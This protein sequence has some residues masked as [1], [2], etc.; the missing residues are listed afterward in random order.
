MSNNKT[1]ISLF[2]I[3]I[4]NVF[5]HSQQDSQYTQYIY[6]TS[7]INPAYAG[8]RETIS[9]FL[10]HRNQWLGLDGGPVTNN[11]AI[12]LPLGYSNFG[13]GLSFTNDKIGP[14]SENEIT[15]DLAYFIQIAKNYKLSVGIKAT[16]NLFH[17][18]I[19]KLTIYDTSD[20]QFQA[21]STEFSPNIGAGLF[22]FS[23]KNYIG[24]SI[25]NFFETY[26]YNDNTVS[27]AKEKI[28]F[29]LIAGK[30]FEIHQNL[31]F[32][33]AIL[34]KVVEGAPIQTDITTNFLFFDKLT[35]GAAYRW[36]VALSGLA[37][38]QISE[39]W[40]VGYGYD[41]E[42]T[43]LN[44]YNSGSHELFLRYELINK[45]KITAPRFF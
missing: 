9:A 36:D 31:K 24:I 26:K 29:Y 22:L 35:L 30:V 13:L 32:K 4:L 3:V 15:S 34:T 23:E 27:I 17:L 8:S 43:R 19:N 14:T 7:N 2:S 20:P 18:D 16:A 33:P 10:L 5:C 6:N 39:S 37:G 38:F 12:S 11:F 40:F 25:P 42:T 1:Y 28:H 44:R 45:T 41:I 21:I